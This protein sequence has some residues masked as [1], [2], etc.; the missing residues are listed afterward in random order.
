MKQR[1]GKALCAGC[2][3]WI[4]K[5]KKEKKSC[6]QCLYGAKTQCIKILIYDRHEINSTASQCPKGCKR[7]RP[8]IKHDIVRTKERKYENNEFH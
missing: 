4:F 6:T 2:I 1:E 3:S 5:R 8:A 7:H